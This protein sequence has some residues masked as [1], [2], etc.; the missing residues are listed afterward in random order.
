MFIKLC[1]IEEEILSLLKN[2]RKRQYDIQVF[3]IQNIFTVFGCGKIQINAGVIV[4]I[5]IDR[6]KIKRTG[7]AIHR[8]SEIKQLSYL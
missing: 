6:T 8:Q 5:Q 1:E 7:I 4:A 2:A 3:E